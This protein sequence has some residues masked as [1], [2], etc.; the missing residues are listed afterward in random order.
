[1]GILW[2]DTDG[3]CEGDKGADA[4]QPSCSAL[5]NSRLRRLW[6]CVR[7]GDRPAELSDEP[8]AG[9]S[10]AV[11]PDAPHLLDLPDDILLPRFERRYSP[12]TADESAM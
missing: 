9:D 12:N 11:R 1:M 3:R 8:C 5:N 6:S 4:S 2:S 7:L 10:F